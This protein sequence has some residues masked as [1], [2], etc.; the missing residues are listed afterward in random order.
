MDSIPIYWSW[1]NPFSVRKISLMVHR[2]RS[3]SEHSKVNRQTMW[4]EWHSP[5]DPVDLESIRNYIKN[6]K[7]D[8]GNPRTTASPF[9]LWRPW[10]TLCPLPLEPLRL[11]PVLLRFLLFHEQ[12]TYIQAR[13]T[14]YAS[15]HTPWHPSIP[16]RQ[17]VSRGEK[18]EKINFREFWR[19]FEPRERVREGGRGAGTW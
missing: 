4:K 8:L 3:H 6:Q 12:I 7:S 15:W 5:E 18:P 10:P 16:D 11:Q 17:R 19:N 9:R 1:I 14:Y 13:F 2:K